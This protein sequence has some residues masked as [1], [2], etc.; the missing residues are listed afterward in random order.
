LYEGL[1]FAARA[2]VKS[3]AEAAEMARMVRMFTVWLFAIF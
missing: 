2:E 1:Q 3:V